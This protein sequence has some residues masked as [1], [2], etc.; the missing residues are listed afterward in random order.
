MTA[1]RLDEPARLALLRRARGAIA[2]AIGAPVEGAASARGLRLS[3]IVEMPANNL[4]LVFER[5]G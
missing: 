4:T 3:E 2:A 1:S 5:A